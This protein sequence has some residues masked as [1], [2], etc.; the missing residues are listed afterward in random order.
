MCSRVG[1]EVASRS[2]EVDANSVTADLEAA[3]GTRIKE[4]TRSRGHLEVA[5][6]W[7]R[8]GLEVGKG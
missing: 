5:S 1:L 6:R 8:G 7:P 4:Q 3:R 2:E